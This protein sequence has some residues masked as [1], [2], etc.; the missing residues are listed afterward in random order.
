[1]NLIKLMKQAATM[2][3]DMAKLQTDLAARTVEFSIGGGMVT[4][5]ARG[6]GSLSGLRIDPKAVDAA[7]VERLQDWVKAAVNGALKAAK[8]VAAQEM[9]KLAGDLGLPPGLGL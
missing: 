7:Q 3:K 5:T 1:M 8:A 9:S 4:A 6:D 2:Q